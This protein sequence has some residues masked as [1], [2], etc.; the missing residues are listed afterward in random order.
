[1]NMEKNY[2]RLRLVVLKKSVLETWQAESG[3]RVFVFRAKPFALIR[4]FFWP[5]TT[6][7]PLYCISGQIANGGAYI[8]KI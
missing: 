1:M 8:F 7:W 2:Q 4:R 3:Q 5:G 6:V